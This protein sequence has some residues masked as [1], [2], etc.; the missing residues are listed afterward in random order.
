VLKNF[1]R[2]PTEAQKAADIAEANTGRELLVACRL[3][4]PDGRKTGFFPHG[5]L[6]VFDDRVVCRIKNLPEVT[7]R[8]GEWTVTTTPRGRAPNQFGYVHLVNKVDPSIHH[9]LRIPNPDLDLIWTIL[10]AF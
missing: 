1:L 3:P 8:R 2:P 9:E 10:S 4:L 7:F 6:H 5:K